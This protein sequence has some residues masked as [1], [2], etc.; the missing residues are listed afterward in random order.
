MSEVTDY[1]KP[2]LEKSQARNRELGHRAG[3][4]RDA[5]RGVQP[6]LRA[7]SM[8]TDLDEKDCAAIRAVETALTD[9]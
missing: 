8:L 4:L 7:M 1:W 2:E 5:L 9:D 3:V 6:M